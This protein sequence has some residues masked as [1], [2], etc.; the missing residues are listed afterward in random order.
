MSDS[1][2]SVETFA[3]TL[4]RETPYLGV[5]RD[6]EQP[7]ARGYLVRK[8]NRT[9]YPIFDRS[10][11]VR[12]ETRNGVVGWGETY[13][14]VAPGAVGAIIGD[15][16]ADFTIGSDP[17]NPSD[18][19]DRLYDLM[20]VRGYTGGFYVDALAAIDIALWDIAGKLAGKPVSKLLGKQVRDTIPA[21]VSGLPEKTLARRV[22]LAET[23]LER[24]FNAFKFATPVADDGPACEL[25]ALR[26]ALGDRVR[27]AADMH[28]NQTSEEA[29]DLIR[30]MEPHGLWF[31]EAP[32]RTE[33][34]AGLEAVC[35]YSPVP[36]AVGEE[37]RTH[38]D[39]LHRIGRCTLSIVQ[40]EM[41]HKGITNFMRIG[42][43]AEQHGL[44][45]IPHATIGAGIF[46]A[47]SLQASASL[48]AVTAHEF[49]HSIF[50]PNRK[51]LNGG[52]EC[53]A[54]V[55]TVP[56]G[57][58]LGVELSKEALALLQPI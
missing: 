16:L 30:A 11:L 10:V 31:A 49:Q 6:G 18:I 36:I 42:Q 38:Y 26:K 39:M 32:V 48:D 43:L 58:G 3:L 29:L 28:W 53:K 22:V 46:L 2:K 47:A 19:Y 54:G 34:I 9:V 13:G 21:Y 51:L 12:I 24:G 7:N 23:W 50:E 15:L 5:A 56:Q 17:A 37:W 4:P 41:G 33:D 35:T 57:A 44:E 20:R 55:Y 25:A 27:I 1:V 52:M 8:G 14:L 40:P 45:V